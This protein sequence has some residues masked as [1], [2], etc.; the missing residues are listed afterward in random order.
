MA[1]MQR[2]VHY[3][4]EVPPHIITDITKSEMLE[5]VAGRETLSTVTL[6]SHMSVTYAQG[7]CEHLRKEQGVLGKVFQFWCSL[8]MLGMSRLPPSMEPVYDSLGRN[9]H[10]CVCL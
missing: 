5:D 4:K 1:S 2:S 3:S 8:G 9:M 10:R 6:D 7:V